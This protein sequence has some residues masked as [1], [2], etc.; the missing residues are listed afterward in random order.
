MN[1]NQKKQEQAIAQA[2]DLQTLVKC[3]HCG[4]TDG[5]FSRMHI[6][7]WGIFDKNGKF[8]GDEA[9]KVEHRVFKRKFCLNCDKEIKDI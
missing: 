5:Y 6:Y 1:E 3:P 7:C 9:E 2:V 8:T 4:S